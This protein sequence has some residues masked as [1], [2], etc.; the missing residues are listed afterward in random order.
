MPY[1][2][3]SSNPFDRDDESYLVLLNSEE[4]HSLWPERIAVPAGWSVVHGPS[5]KA[6]CDAY[7]NQTWTDLRPR[8]LRTASARREAA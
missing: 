7:I 1:D 6:A 8:S 3:E 2:A 4:Q 5:P